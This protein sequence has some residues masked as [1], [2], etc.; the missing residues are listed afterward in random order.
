MLNG[1]KS[2][3][4]TILDKDNKVISNLAGTVPVY[5]KGSSR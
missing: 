1:S 4:I 5:S 3:F 2:G